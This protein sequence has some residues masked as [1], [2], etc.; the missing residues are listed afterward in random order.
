M[1]PKIIKNE[2]DAYGISQGTF[3][4]RDIGEE[5]EQILADTRRE[6]EEIRRQAAQIF[7]QAKQALAD[8]RA[9]AKT[10]EDEARKRG[11]EEGK[12]EGIKEGIPV[13]TKQG[14]E[15]E[16]KHVME[17]TENL[18]ENLQQILAQTEVK[19][20]SLFADAR[21]SILRFAI[22]V[23]E[24]IVRA[25]VEVDDE[26]VLRNIEAAVDLIAQERKLQI[27]INPSEA[28]VVQEYVPH[29]KSSSPRF[30]SIHIT[31]DESIGRGCCIVRTEAGQVDAT[32]QTQF[33]EIEK[34]L[35]QE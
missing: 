7:E 13:G 8:V 18:R 26:A 17:K 12:Q 19:R 2:R 9:R 22:K 30:E 29:L 3:S 10:L 11:F 4:L 6:A 34:Q 27:C 28:E 1:S 14:R 35:I 23:A 31:P 20:E 15:E 32:V 21:K 25:R 5:C 33:E 16:V 24:K